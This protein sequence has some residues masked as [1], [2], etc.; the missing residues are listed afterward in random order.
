MIWTR[1]DK[2]GKVYF[3]TADSMKFDTISE[4]IHYLG[5]FSNHQRFAQLAT[6]FQ[7]NLDRRDKLEVI[8]ENLKN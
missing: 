6:H 7:K 8:I 4:A 2:N 5:S 3:C 1:R